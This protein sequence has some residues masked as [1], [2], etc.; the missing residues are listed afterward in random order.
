LGVAFGGLIAIL[1]GIG[2]LGLRRMQAIDQTLNDITGRQSTNLELARRAL[3]LSNIN[4]RIN[5]EIVLVENRA[6]VETLL[7]TMAQNSKEITRLVEESEKR[8]E[9]EE[10]RQLLSTVKRTRKP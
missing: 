2:Q 8:C 6:L 10:E 1:L 9:S 5:M 7:A 4:S 3:M